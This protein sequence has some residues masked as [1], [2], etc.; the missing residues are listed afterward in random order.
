MSS[1][2]YGTRGRIGIGTPQA[3]PTVEPE[4]QLLLPD[5]VASYVVRLTSSAGQPADRLRAYLEELDNTLDR[6]DSLIL[7][8]FLFACTGSSYLLG[9]DRERELI[10]HIQSRRGFTILTAGKAIQLELARLGARKIAIV[11]PYPESITEAA[12]TYWTDTGIEV[13][14]IRRIE[15]RSADTRSIYELGSQDAMTAV[16]ALCDEGAADEADAIVLTG[17]GMPTARILREAADL[18]GRPVLSSNQCLVSAS[19]RDLGL[20]TAAAFDR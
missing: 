20:A 4:I 13:L 15:T 8:N 6:Y 11:A 1:F 18:S 3:N 17:T 10:A 2:D 19:L 5:S 14:T 16:Q 9:L 12:R 7:D